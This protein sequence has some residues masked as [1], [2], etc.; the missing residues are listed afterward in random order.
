MVVSIRDVAAAASVSV[1]T[2]S[3]VLNRPS[4]VAPAT[5]ERVQ[6][7]IDE[8]G[9][10][11]N[12]AARQLR[13]GRSRSIGLV[14]LDAG[15]PFFADVARGAEARADEADM[16]V[17]LGNADEDAQRETRYLDL[18]LEQ[19][20]NG[21]LITPADDDTRRLARL[22][23]AGTP[24]IL[25][26]REVPGS[27]FSSVSVDDV[28]G[29]F[30]A[31]SHLLAAGRR[32]VMFLGGPRSIRQVADRLEGA[33]RAVDAVD[34]ATLQV[35]EMPALTVLHGR[36]AGLEVLERATGERPD[37]IFAANDL[38]AV[39]AIQALSILSGVRIPDD[40]ALIGY[41]DIDFAASTIV[42]LSSIRQ[43]ATLIGYTAVD[44]LLSELDDPHGDHERNVRFQPELV[45]RESTSG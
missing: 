19:R 21:V 12:D 31:A 44:L 33:R 8:L 22:R 23:D 5:V 45:V 3:N 17:L 6:R 40:I 43:P 25:V 7:A 10:V 24:V 16:A 42:P 28:E 35:V 41:D 26:D 14:V 18:F 13:V 15:N 11:R 36:A 2:V 39:G 1:G 20:V 4:K 27:G 30:L 37:A 9:F 34:G 32:R 38:L 29:G